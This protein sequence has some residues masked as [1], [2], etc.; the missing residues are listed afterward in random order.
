MLLPHLRLHVK[1]HY[2]A[3]YKKADMLLLCDILSRIPWNI[4]EGTSD[5]ED[6]WQLFKDLFL[7]A[8]NMSVPRL[9]MEK[10]EIEALVFLPNYLFNPS[11]MVS[12]FT[13]QVI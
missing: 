1:D 9:T 10:E 13:Y 4:I 8:E 2:I 11:K 3:N 12:I 5:V 7:S 6:L